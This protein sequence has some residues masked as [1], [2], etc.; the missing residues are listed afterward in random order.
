MP[1]ISQV[2][3][4]L[5]L[6][7]ISIQT[8]NDNY[9]SET[10]MPIVPVR[11]E[12]SKYFT[13]DLSRFDAPPAL[14]AERTKYG[15]VEF[16]LSTDSYSCEE[17]GLEL[18]IDDR[19]RQNAIEPINVDVDSTEILTD[20]VLNDREQRVCNVVL[21]AGNYT[22]SN[23]VDYGSTNPLAW[24]PSNGASDPIKDIVITGREAIRKNIGHYPNGLWLGAEVFSNLKQHPL[25]VDRIKYNGSNQPVPGKVTLQALADLFEVD[26]VY[27]GLPL[28]RT[29]NPNQTDVLADVWG[30]NALLA[31]VNPRPMIKQISLAYM[32]QS[33]PR[34]VYKYRD[35]T[36]SSDI[37]R[38]SEVTAEKLV[39][40]KCGYLFT[41]VLG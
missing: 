6:T 13:Y 5:M 34:Q 31:Y 15:R 22:H 40:D 25:I 35:D 8:K 38:C 41:N 27:V 7:N 2:R 12:S 24:L 39:A 1:L 9:L 11:L 17:Y 33:R 3:I 4:D 20:M 18:P 21:T 14:R 30:K 28:R 16:Q 32:F 23:T 36:I 37:I 19:E 26:N 10:I 29:S